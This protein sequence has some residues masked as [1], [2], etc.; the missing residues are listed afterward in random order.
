MTG[1]SLKKLHAAV[2]HS[3]V[4]ASANRI[5]P[6]TMLLSSEAMR[7]WIAGQLRERSDAKSSIRCASRN[8]KR[9]WFR[10]K[11]QGRVFYSP[12]GKGAA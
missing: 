12:E 3:F 7:A 6:Q 2:S 11:C 9:P 5:F 4:T 1:A 10:G 8:K